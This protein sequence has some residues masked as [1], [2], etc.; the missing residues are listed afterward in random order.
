MVE[1][2][3]AA[4]AWTL[5][6][7]FIDGT[8]ASK[9][10][11]TSSRQSLPR[12]QG[13]RGVSATDPELHRV[14]HYLAAGV[15]GFAFF[16]MELVWYRMLGPILGGTTYTFGL[17]LAVVL[18]SVLAL[19]MPAI[20]SCFVAGG[21]NAGHVRDHLWPG[22]CLHGAVP[23]ALGDRLAIFQA[24]V[25][26]EQSS[27]FLQSVVDWT[28]IAGVVVFP[29]ALISGIQYPL[30]V[31]LLGQ[32]RQQIGRQVGLCGAWNTA[33]AIA[34]SLAGGFG[35]LPPPSAPGAWRAVVVLLA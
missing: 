12:G 31:S 20:R 23:F 30:L 33:G 27:S 9:L 2:T 8:V 16:L 25:W 6:R 21:P 10:P 19:G 26:A 14:C 29:A 11:P 4:G 5:S 35:V 17:L 3:V 15:V 24:A 34:G 28:L 32:G 22:S 7:R 1:L 13:S 18:P